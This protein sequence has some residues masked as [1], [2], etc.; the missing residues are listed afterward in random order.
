[1]TQW[2][3][4]DK[5]FEPSADE[6]DPKNVYGFI[7]LIE[8]LVPEANPRLYIGKKLFWFK[9][10]KSVKLKNGKKKRKRTL[11]ESD[12]KEYY[13]SNK[14]LLEDVEKYGKEN[15][16]RTILHLCKNKGTCSYLEMKEQVERKA[17]IDSAYYNE[18]IRVR[19]HRSHLKGIL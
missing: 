3:Y 7:Y 5:P 2:L 8:N 10:Y 14:K 17:I 11:V 6:F 15:F 16:R 1:M 12:W 19:I 18:Q 4:D 13:G 9:G